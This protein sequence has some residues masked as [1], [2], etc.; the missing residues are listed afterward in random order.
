MLLTINILIWNIF[1][2]Y[3]THEFKN[4]ILQRMT[5]HSYDD[6]YNWCIKK[7]KQMYSQIRCK[8]KETVTIT[9]DLIYTCIVSN[10]Q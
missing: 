10:I 4:T 5:C 8:V 6:I 7:L 3:R 9:Y 2:G 1:I